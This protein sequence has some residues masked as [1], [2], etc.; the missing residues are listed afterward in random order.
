MIEK[1]LKYFG[2][3][4]IKELTP[5]QKKE[6]LQFLRWKKRRISLMVKSDFAKV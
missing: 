5:E 1:I 6:K 2:Y 3:V 4:K